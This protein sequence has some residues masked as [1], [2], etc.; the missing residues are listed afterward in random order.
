MLDAIARIFDKL[1]NAPKGGNRLVVG[2]GRADGFP[3]LRDGDVALN[4]SS[5]SK[6]DIIGDIRNVDPSKL[7]TFKEIVFERIPFDVLLRAELRSHF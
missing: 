6:A 5:A 1:E 3:A 7:G 4:I 2:G